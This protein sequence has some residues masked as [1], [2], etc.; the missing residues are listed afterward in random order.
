MIISKVEYENINNNNVDLE[1]DSNYPGYYPEFFKEQYINNVQELYTEPDNSN[2]NTIISKLI[3]I[4]DDIEDNNDEL[5]KL[6][7][8]TIYNNENNDNDNDNVNYNT[9][10]SIT[11]SNKSSKSSIKTEINIFNE[12]NTKSSQ[13]TKKTSPIRPPSNTEL[14]KQLKD[15]NKK[16]KKQ[17]YKTSKSKN[18]QLLISKL[19]GFCEQS[20]NKKKEILNFAIKQDITLSIDDFKYMDEDEIEEIYQLIKNI[21]I[22]KQ[23]FNTSMIIIKLIFVCIEK[24]LVDVFKLTEF[25][26]M[27]SVITDEF[28]D[29]KCNT[30]K[31]FINNYVSTPNIPFMDI[32]IQ[33]V[34]IGIKNYFNVNLI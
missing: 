29:N 11:K 8:E 18:M 5:N 27:V 33:I 12:Q 21:N 1:N 6:F 7:D 13:F 23:S 17:Q 3:P 9:S 2:T 10:V 22:H 30:T 14:L 16:L 20:L 19:N 15:E 32:G 24:C 4:D 26:N 25:K 31:T 34:G 28:I